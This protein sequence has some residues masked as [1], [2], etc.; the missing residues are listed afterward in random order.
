M[1]DN[2][3]RHMALVDLGV[4]LGANLVVFPELSLTGYEPARAA[5]LSRFSNDS[6]LE[7]FQQLCDQNDVS[8]GVGFP[9]RTEGLPRISALLFRPNSTPLIYSKRYLHPDEEPYFDSGT[10]ADSTIHSSPKVALAICY[11]LSVPQHAQMAFDAGATAY[12]ASVAKTARGIEDASQQLSDIARQNSAL[13]MLSNCLGVHDGV[14]CVGH[15]SAWDR[16]GK[17]LA[18]LDSES[19]GVIVVDHDT[20]YV[21]TDSLTTT[22]Q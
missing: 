14:E 12:I 11:E 2:V 3:T 16:K 19:D 13:V 15:S 20:G 17:L 18:R 8:I 1:Q 21:L 10:V 9:L 5:E 22:G 7:G 4:R 6:C